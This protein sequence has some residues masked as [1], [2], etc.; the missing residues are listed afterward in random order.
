M[1]H[2][3]PQFEPWVDEASARLGI[4]R[5][6]VAAQIAQ[7]SNWDNSSVGQYNE[8]GIVQFTPDTWKQYGG[9]GDP[10]NFQDELEAYV[11]YMSYLLKLEH[12]NV[13]LAL[14]AYNGGP[15]GTAYGMNYA[16]TIIQAAGLPNLNP[17]TADNSGVSL[18]NSNVNQFLQ[19]TTPLSLD[20]LKSEYPLVAAL[21]TS[22]PE[23]QDIAKQASDPASPWSMDRIVAAVQNSQ[24]YATHSD[25]ARELIAI[26]KSD[27]TTYSQRVDNL[28][29]QLQ[30]MASQ[31]GVQMTS[32][33]LQALGID[34]M[35][36]GYDQNTAVLN[37]KMAQFLK[38]ASG[39][40]FGGQAGSYEDQI[41]QSMRDLGVFMPES[42]LDNQIQQIVAGKQSVQG[43]NAQ[44]RSQ[45][46]AMYPAYSQQINSGMNLS[47]IASPYMSRAQQLLEQ[48]PG[49]VNIQSPL[50]KSALQ[51]TQDGQPT[52][53]PM[54]D[55]EKSV[56]QDPRWLSTD[57]AQDAFMSNAHQVLVN[58]GF[59]Y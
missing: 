26:M 17:A 46:A 27:P 29:Y 54:Y 22:V 8:K 11:N 7:E 4:P 23:L 57:N 55:F 36:S 2:V 37:Q 25:T 6:L 34:A 20:Q 35:M 32:Q 14:A 58:F 19:P 47:D 48:G 12:G 38:P 39:N 45:S 43:V 59:E 42:Q 10:T 9:G 16:N 3:P 13:Q 41:R 15:G 24:W 33:Q 40:H 31:L 51:Y 28:S 5:S 56:R 18:G 44:L 50:I 53:M 30:S 1:V 52:A 21:L 49:S